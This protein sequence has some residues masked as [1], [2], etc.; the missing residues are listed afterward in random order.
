MSNKLISTRQLAALVLKQSALSPLEAMRPVPMQRD[1]IVAIA[2]ETLAA[3]E[4]YEASLVYLSV[5]CR[6]RTSSKPP[7]PHLSDF[8]LAVETFK[9]SRAKF[10][11]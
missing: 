1:F 9:N 2:A 5:I 10:Y 11:I 4:F 6:T 7:K 8:L 3:R